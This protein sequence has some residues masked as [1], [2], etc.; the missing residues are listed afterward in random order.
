M[1]NLE[2]VI[3]YMVIYGLMDLLTLLT[4][5][6][7]LLLAIIAGVFFTKQPLVE[8]AVGVAFG[9]A[10]TFYTAVY[11]QKKYG[12]RRWAPADGITLTM[13]AFSSHQHW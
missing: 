7:V 11:Y 6:Y 9:L 12:F 8:T 5:T 4:P 10:M 3:A 13:T 1:N 2:F